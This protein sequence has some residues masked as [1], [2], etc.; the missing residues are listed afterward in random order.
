MG[1]TLISLLLLLIPGLTLAMLT[2]GEKR[3]FAE[4]IADSVGYSIAVIAILFLSTFYLPIRLT[5]PFFYIFYSI[6]GV[7]LI[8]TFLRQKSFPKFSWD[9]PLTLVIFSSI[10]YLRFY[11]VKDLV[12]PA[13]VDSVHH[14]LITKV[15]LEGGKIPITLEPYLAAP[16][17]YYFGFHGV[18]AVFS[19][20]SSLP[21]EKAILIL[22][23]VL[24]ACMPLAIYRLG[25]AIWNDRIRAFIAAI[26][27]AFVSQMPAYY[28][29]WGRYTLLTGMIM[30]AIALAEMIETSR[31]P[32]G[33]RYGLLGML[34]IGLTLSHYFSVL[35]FIL[36][37]IPF[38][39]SSHYR[40]G[41]RLTIFEFK[42]PLVVALA[43]LLLT[44]W[45]IRAFQLTGYKLNPDINIQF[46]NEGWQSVLPYA[47]YLF[48]LAGPLRNYIL[49]TI[50]VL[51]IIPT[52]LDQK[53][54]IL[55][56]WAI[57]ILLASLPLWINLPN[58]RTDHMIIILFFPMS[59]TA[60]CFLVS[61]G[62][63]ISR[64]FHQKTLQ[65][66][67]YSIPMIGFCIWGIID[68]SSIINPVTILA[69]QADVS[70]IQWIK[71]GVD[72][73]AR[74]LINSA[75]WQGSVYR[76]VDGGYWLLPLTG[77]FTIPPPVIFSW[78]NG[79]TTNSINS[80][81]KRISEIKT[82]DQ[83]F[84]EV[85]TEGKITNIYIKDGVGSIQ[86]EALI[87]CNGLTR[88]YLNQG[89][90]IFQVD[91]NQQNSLNHSVNQ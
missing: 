52:I 87:S 49:L 4:L 21:P 73:A 83:D 29:T 34:V 78:G 26:L 62:K 54:R 15:I 79:D 48:K 19:N 5:G 11:Q 82:C 91:H 41:Q 63:T 30:L 1:L 22:G 12:L 56:F 55:G 89:V 80:L 81:A 3:S 74:F 45:L 75:A 38:L 76:G 40:T 68:T 28:V 59:L 46:L 13:W 43:F 25:H 23:Q 69:T 57:V 86:S 70:A 88:I 35:L 16:F 90:S 50:G 18:A 58:I 53:S 8:I 77:R 44:P 42:V 60:A 72:P 47:Q 65:L 14:V 31:K 27:V 9:V 64:T 36:F 7:I 20:L 51:G 24:N 6:A 84:W 66:L 32:T 33:Y 39:A 10:I 17:S 71:N 67:F 37:A 2:P 61:I 85:I